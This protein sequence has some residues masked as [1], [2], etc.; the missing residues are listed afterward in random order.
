MFIFPD[1]LQ[2]LA[3]SLLSSG[4][5]GSHDYSLSGNC[6]PLSTSCHQHPAAPNLS[7]PA[8]SYQHGLSSVVKVPH[9][10]NSAEPLTD[11]HLLAS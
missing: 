9:P 2:V 8:P 7:T 4:P 10:I 3:F 5:S 1:F 11:P 6:P